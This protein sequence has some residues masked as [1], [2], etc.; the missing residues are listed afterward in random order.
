MKQIFFGVYFLGAVMAVLAATYLDPFTAAVTLVLFPLAALELLIMSGRVQ[1]HEG[2]PDEHLNETDA[3]RFPAMAESDA[4]DMSDDEAI[5]KF[6]QQLVNEM[7]LMIT[8]KESEL[9]EMRS[10]RDDFSDK[11]RGVKK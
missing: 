5:E 2:H 4:K 7:S 10:V 11:V 1:F 8:E 6:G 3:Q 9:N